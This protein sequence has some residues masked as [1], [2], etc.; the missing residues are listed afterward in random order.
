MAAARAAP[1][2][3][4]SVAGTAFGRAARGWGM[5]ELAAKRVYADRAGDRTLLVAAEAGLVTVA[6]S[7]GRV[8]GFGVARECD[9]ADLA[10]GADGPLV[11]ATDADVLVSGSAAVDDLD[12]TGFG[13]ATAV[14]VHEGCPMAAGP[15]DR[16]AALESDGWDELG[17]LPGPA[18]AMAGGLVATPAGVIRVVD[19]ELRPAGLEEVADV[20][21]AAG[22]PLAATADGLYELGNGW[23]DVLEGRFELVAG[24]PDGRA[25][26]AGEPGAFERVDGGWRP[27]DLPVDDPIAA[28]ALGERTALL[29]GEGVLL[30]EADEVWGRHP[31]GLAGV[32][33]AAGG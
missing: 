9:P 4:P 6:I 23:L 28:A 14:A 5:D 24:A 15:D 27:L 29:T 13:A 3:A 30:L 8:G 1:G 21:L 31:L 26:A 32:V 20:A 33:A 16:L 10:V 7:G 17:E 25:V 12:G 18:A 19:G 2:L 11:V 22:M